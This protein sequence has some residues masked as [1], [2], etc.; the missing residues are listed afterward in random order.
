MAKAEDFI[1]ETP[2]LTSRPVAYAEIC[3]GGG[4]LEPKTRLL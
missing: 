3:E 4:V 2:R 1:L